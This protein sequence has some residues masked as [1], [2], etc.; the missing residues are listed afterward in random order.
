MERFMELQVLGGFKRIGKYKETMQD[1][2]DNFL[3]SYREVE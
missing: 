1:L 2:G 3:V